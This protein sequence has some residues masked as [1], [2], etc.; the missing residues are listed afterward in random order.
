[1]ETG[2]VL[3]FAATFAIVH[4]IKKLIIATDELLYIVRFPVATNIIGAE[5]CVSKTQRNY[6]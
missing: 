4:A 2:V 6:R 3:L 1:M 5:S